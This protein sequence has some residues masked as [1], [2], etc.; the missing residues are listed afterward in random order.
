M[1]KHI[2]GVTKADYDSVS[3]W[4]NRLWKQQGISTDKHCLQAKHKA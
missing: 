3:S 1:A 4:L 2:R